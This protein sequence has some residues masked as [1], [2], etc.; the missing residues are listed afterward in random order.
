MPHAPIHR[1]IVEIDA[2]GKVVGRLASEIARILMGKHKATYSPNVDAGDIVRVKNAAKIRFTGNKLEQKHYFNY[3]GYPGG[4]K[5]R[6]AK[7]VMEKNPTRILRSA[8]DR[9]LPKNTLR[10][11]R[12]KR[13]TVVK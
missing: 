13:L 5:A 7:D 4:M 8:V 11:R 10:A 6:R 1:K 9:M 2:D 3:S 12:I